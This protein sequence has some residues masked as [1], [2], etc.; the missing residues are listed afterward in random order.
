[1]IDVLIGVGVVLGL[2]AVIVAF[3]RWDHRHPESRPRG[4]VGPM[5]EIFQPTNHQA[6]AQW[7]EQQ[8]APAPPP[9]PGDPPHA[10]DPL[11]DPR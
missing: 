10:E 11:R 8:R 6:Q 7:E 5:G 3:V 2:L 1:M 9:L 4:G